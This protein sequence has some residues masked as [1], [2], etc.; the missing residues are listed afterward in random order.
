M[1]TRSASKTVTR[2]PDWVR[3]SLPPVFSALALLQSKCKIAA[4]P[5]TTRSGY[6]P[7]SL[8][9]TLR[10]AAREFPVVVLT[11]PRQSGRRPS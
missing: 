7:R 9:R 1:R 10:R 5:P 3:P 8:E 6:I 2:D 4:M 11:G